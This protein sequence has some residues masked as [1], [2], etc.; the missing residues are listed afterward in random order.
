MKRQVDE[1]RTG[2]I[3]LGD[4]RIGAQLAGDRFREVPRLLAGILGEHH[5]RIGRHIP[6]G[7]VS[8]RFDHHAGLI[9]AGRQ[10]A[11][12]DQRVVGRADAIQHLG[13]NILGNHQEKAVQIRD[14]AVAGNAIGRLSQS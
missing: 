11:G 14:Y 9:D 12:G 10:L 4:K 13:E 5:R 7:R 3:D 6:M 2:H 1:A 8:R